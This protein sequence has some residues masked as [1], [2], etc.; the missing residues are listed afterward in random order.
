MGLWELCCRFAPDNGSLKALHPTV[1]VMAFLFNCRKYSTEPAKCKHKTE[2]KT[3]K[4][5]QNLP[6]LLPYC[7]ASGPFLLPRFVL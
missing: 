3:I 4:D 5:F 7:S 2:K 1:F 6:A